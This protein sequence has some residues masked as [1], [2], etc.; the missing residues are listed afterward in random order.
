M[1]LAA[2]RLAAVT[3]APVVKMVQAERLARA[4]GRWLVSTLEPCT[5]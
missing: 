2:A 1:H 4:H 5:H 3:L